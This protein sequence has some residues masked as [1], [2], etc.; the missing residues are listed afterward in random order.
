[1][2]KLDSSNSPS[3]PSSSSVAQPRLQLADQRLHIM[4]Q[5]H[6]S[7]RQRQP[8]NAAMRL[9]QHP[10]I[11]PAPNMLPVNPAE[12]TRAGAASSHL[13]L[14]DLPTYSSLYPGNYPGFTPYLGPVYPYSNHYPTMPPRR[15]GR[16]DIA[17]NTI[18]DN[19][20]VHKARSDAKTAKDSD[21]FGVTQTRGG[22]LTH[23]SLAH[24][25]NEHS[26][27]PSNN[28]AR[29]TPGQAKRSSLNNRPKNSQPQPHAVDPKAARKRPGEQADAL[30][31]DPPFPKP[32]TSTSRYK[33]PKPTKTTQIKRQDTP[34]SNSTTPVL[35]RRPRNRRVVLDEDD[36][37]DSPLASIGAHAASMELA[38]AALVDPSAKQTRNPQPRYEYPIPKELEGVRQALGLENWTEYLFHM[39]SLWTGESTAD[40]FAANTKRLFLIF[41]DS[42]RKRMN[43]MVAMKVVVPVLEQRREEEEQR[44]KEEMAEGNESAPHSSSFD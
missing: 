3:T 24:P 25:E 29:K 13:F 7:Q 35:S 9:P 33:T 23:T 11:G 30:K 8:P 26:R 28:A 10:F 12:A 22:T 18:N 16:L 38:L 41:N 32:D 42:I 1:M 39:E 2:S 36:E 19:D 15:S 5:E 34:L 6:D 43:N 31:Q 20:L 21:L 37:T 27:L 17:N 14:P 40:E 4:S 44:I